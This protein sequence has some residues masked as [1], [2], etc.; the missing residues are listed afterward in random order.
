AFYIRTIVD[1][2]NILVAYVIARD[3]SNLQQLDLPLKIN[4]PVSWSPNSR[5]LTMIVDDTNLAIYDIATQTTRTIIGENR[6]FAPSWSP[7]GRWIAFIENRQLHLYDIEND[8]GQTL[9]T[10]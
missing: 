5:Q 4:S 10:N 8:D 3:G 9:A 1:G 6:R 7:G 2:S